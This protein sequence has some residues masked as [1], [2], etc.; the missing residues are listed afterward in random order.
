MVQLSELSSSQDLADPRIKEILAENDDDYED[1]EDDLQVEDEHDVSSESLLERLSALVDIIPPVQRTK[2]LHA[3][4]DVAEWTVGA[5]QTLGSG[6]WILSTGSL[7]M[8]L[9][10]TL[11]L[12]RERA[13]IDQEV[14]QRMQQQQ[15]QQVCLVKKINLARLCNRQLTPSRRVQE[16]HFKKWHSWI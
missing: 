4:A 14:Q 8:F 5:F 1:I 16:I 3:L 10:M 2:A 13:I 11:E 7:L 9:P 12:E 15:A 6:I